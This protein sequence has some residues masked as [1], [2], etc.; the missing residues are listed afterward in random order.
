MFELLVG[1]LRL[2]FIVF[3]RSVSVMVNL[4]VVKI[5]CDGVSCFGLMKVNSF[6][7]SFFWFIVLRICTM[8]LDELIIIVNM[9]DIDVMMIGY[10][11]YEV[12][13]VVRLFHGVVV[14]LSEFVLVVLRLLILVYM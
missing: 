12:Y 2:L 13:V 11:I 9:F 1:L 8:L 6:G 4:F 3:I 10:F 7:N 5:V 14:L